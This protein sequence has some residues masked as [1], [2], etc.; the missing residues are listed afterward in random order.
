[1]SS[2]PAAGTSRLP[3]LLIVGTPV[4]IILAASWLWY[5]VA[6]GQ[7][8]LVAALGTSNNGTLITPPRQ[9]KDAE[10][11]D[12]AGAAFRW[13]DMDP[14]WTMVVVNRGT[15]CGTSC[16]DRLYLTRQLHIALGK[17]FNRIRRVMI[18][19]AGISEVSIQAPEMSQSTLLT[20]YL[21]ENHKGLVPLA[22]A[23]G[24][25]E[26]S[27]AELTDQPNQWF[28]VDPAGWIMMRFDDATSLEARRHRPNNGAARRI[29]IFEYL[30]HQWKRLGR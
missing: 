3:L 14:R 10:F 6:Q 22:V 13:Q 8:D 20:D 29:V 1:M 21:A 26:Q 11:T 5:F 30:M 28:L 27:F 4:I 17:E 12:D 19:D 7:L 2:S 23:A 15:I 24:R 25:L 18:S 9:I 16:I